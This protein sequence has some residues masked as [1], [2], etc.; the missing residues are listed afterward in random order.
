MVL[1]ATE[2]YPPELE[3]GGRDS[4]PLYSL[5]I[6]TEPL[7]DEA[8]KAHRWNDGL[9]IGDRHHLFFYAQRTSDGRIAIGGRGAPDRLWGARRERNRA[10]RKRRAPG[11]QGAGR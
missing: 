4:L 10:A 5:M 11:G 7:P 3:G 2:S 6:A 8:W 1:G 9:L